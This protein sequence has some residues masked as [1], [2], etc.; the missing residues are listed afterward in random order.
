MAVTSE[1]RNQLLDEMLLETGKYHYVDLEKPVSV[2]VEQKPDSLTLDH[3]PMRPWDGCK[4]VWIC[5]DTVRNYVSESEDKKIVDDYIDRGVDGLPQ[6]LRP[7]AALPAGARMSLVFVDLGKDG[8]NYKYDVLKIFNFQNGATKAQAQN[9][10]TG[11]PSTILWREKQAW[12]MKKALVM[13][14]NKLHSLQARYVNI[15]EKEE[16]PANR[17]NAPAG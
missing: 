9:L 10:I 11:S 16:V 6:S 4:K 17:E 13:F 2:C 8:A 1:Q 7:R 12:T 14:L 15:S 3:F 5:F